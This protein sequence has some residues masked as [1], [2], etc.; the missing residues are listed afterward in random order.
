[1]FLHFSDGIF[2]AIAAICRPRGNREASDAWPR[3]VINN[4]SS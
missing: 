2:D 1:M 3:T 4:K